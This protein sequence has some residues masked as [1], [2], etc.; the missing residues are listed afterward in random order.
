MQLKTKNIIKNKKLF[1]YFIASNIE[2]GMMR[3]CNRK[4]CIIGTLI[5][6]IKTKINGKI[7]SLKKYLFFNPDFKAINHTK[8]VGKIYAFINGTRPVTNFTKI[9]NKFL[10][11]TVPKVKFQFI[12][13]PSITLEIVYCFKI[14]GNK[15]K[16]AA[17]SPKLKNSITNKINID[18]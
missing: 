16:I 3:Y 7:K 6:N 2:R 9:K 17:N 1:L 13:S 18:P 8:I 4:Y 15:T 5:E 10:K 14:S 12:T 11:F